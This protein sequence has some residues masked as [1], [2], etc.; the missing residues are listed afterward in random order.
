MP[1]KNPEIASGRPE[2]TRKF[3]GNPTP[4]SHA[5][6]FEWEAG[7]SGFCG[8][9]RKSPHDFSRFASS[10]DR[11]KG[12]RAKVGRNTLRFCYFPHLGRSEVPSRIF[13]KSIAD[14]R[15]N[16][17]LFPKHLKFATIYV[18][19]EHGP[20]SPRRACEPQA[21]RPEPAHAQH[22]HKVL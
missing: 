21:R 6:F 7:I 19:F 4:E 9:R 18:C 5:V 14:G 13:K 2:G 20:D 16:S 22:T 11:E 12:A 17:G 1:R 15:E 8:F 3:H 10:S